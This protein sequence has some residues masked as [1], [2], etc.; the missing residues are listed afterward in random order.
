MIELRDS[1]GGA[2]CNEHPS[3]HPPPIPSQPKVVGE[4]T[5]PIA[6]KIWVCLYIL[7][8]YIIYATMLPGKETDQNASQLKRICALHWTTVKKHILFQF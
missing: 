4:S 3:Y 5:K 6:R 8:P 7:L 1:K 2:E